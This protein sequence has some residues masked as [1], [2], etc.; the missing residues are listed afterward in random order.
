MS[1]DIQALIKIESASSSDVGGH[2][3]PMSDEIKDC[4]GILDRLP[5]MKVMKAKKAMKA[6]KKKTASKVGK[7]RRAKA[8]KVKKAM[9]VMKMKST[10]KVAKGPRAKAVVLRDSTGRK[11]TVGGLT[12]KDLIKNKKDRVVSKKRSV[13]G[14]ASPWIIAVKKARAALSIVC[15]WCLAQGRAPHRRVFATMCRPRSLPT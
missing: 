14:A 3:V 13:N 7:G 10:S 12:A 4:I 8:V 2:P 11:K 15:Q 9:K 5:G 6:M 1:G